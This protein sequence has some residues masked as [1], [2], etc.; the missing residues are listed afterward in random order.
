MEGDGVRGVEGDHVEWRACEAVSSV[1]SNTR[2]TA[3]LPHVTCER[4]TSA[5]VDRRKTD[6]AQCSGNRETLLTAT[7]SKGN[8]CLQ[9]QLKIPNPFTLEQPT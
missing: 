2:Y 5:E 4:I 7:L 8:L 6:R 9:E 1:D 3:A